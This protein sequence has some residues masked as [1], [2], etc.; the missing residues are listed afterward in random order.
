MIQYHYTYILRL[1]NGQEYIGVRSSKVLPE[2]DTQYLGTSKYFKK[3]D[4]AF[5]SI[6]E[7][8]KSRDEAAQHEIEL[9][10]RY[11][12]GRNPGFANRAKAT[13]SRLAFNTQGTTRTE[14]YKE[15]MRSVMKGKQNC[16]NKKNALGSK[17]SEA[18]KK[19]YSEARM[20]NKYSLGKNLGNK[21]GVSDVRY[22]FHHAIFGELVCTQYELRTRFD[23]DQGNLSNL[24]YGKAKSVKG[25]ALVK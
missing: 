18:T 13:T 15:H 21:N 7:T 6:I 25:W 19:A 10:D 5:K 20:G 17:H 4:V 3:Q 9:H 2:L 14:E 23:L 24:C 22:R 11:D 1:R 12:V 16:L 8:F